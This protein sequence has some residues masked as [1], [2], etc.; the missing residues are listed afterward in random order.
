MVLEIRQQRLSAARWHT[1]ML[2]LVLQVYVVLLFP[3]LPC[4]LAHWL[5]DWLL[6]FSA[7]SQEFSLEVG[8]GDHDNSDVVK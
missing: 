4:R 2:S 8:E 6:I 1:F 7:M 5:W 3:T